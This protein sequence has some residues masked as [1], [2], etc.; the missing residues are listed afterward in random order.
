MLFF[1]WLYYSVRKQLF[2]P[3][4]SPSSKTFEIVFV[5]SYQVAQK[6]T[7]WMNL[8]RSY[9]W[10]IILLSCITAARG[11]QCGAGY[12]QKGQNCRPCPAGTYSKIA[13]STECFD[14][15]KNTF[16]PYEAK[17]NPIYCRPCP[18]NAYS[19][20]GSASCT[21]CPPGFV[22]A[23]ES[24]QCRRCRGA[25]CRCANSKI[26][27][28]TACPKG[29][30]PEKEEPSYFATCVD[31]ATGCPPRTRLRNRSVANVC[32]DKMERVVCPPSHIYDGYQRCLSCFGNGRIV[33][34]SGTD[35]SFFSCSL[36]PSQTISFYGAVSK[37]TLCPPGFFQKVDN[38]VPVC[39]NPYPPEV[40]P[41]LY[42][43]F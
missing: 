40:D 43:I 21:T 34:R 24:L 39:Y 2:L 4:F 18:I 8:F 6:V 5:K 12:F 11:A 42:T 19:K 29:F 32:V 27:C 31:P 15:P 35:F 1:L 20:P 28:P 25:D 7:P 9:A 14:C 22:R 13:V 26:R 10:S 38:G 36:C 17:P 3:S 41:R 30:G 37:C 23:G 16:R 33:Y